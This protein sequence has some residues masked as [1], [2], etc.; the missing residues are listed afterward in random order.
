MIARPL[1]KAS[2]TKSSFTWT[3]E[4][5]EAFESLKKHLSSTPILAFP[6]F[7]EPF[8][9]YTDASV[10]AM[11]AVLAQVQDGK[12]R[13]ICYASKAFSKSQTNYSATKRELLA[14]VTFTRHFKHYLLG[15]KFR[16]VTDHHALQW[17]HNFKDPDGL[18]AR[19]LKKLAAFDYEV[20]HRPGKS[21][22]HADGL[23]RIPIANQV[24]SSQCQEK[25]DEPMKTKF[26]EIVHKN[27][28]LFQSKGS[29]AHCISSEFKMSAG[30][31]RSLKRKFPYNFPEI[32][33][34][35]LFVQK[36]DDRFIY[37]L[38]TKRRFFQK[39]TYD[40]LRQSLEAM[41]Y[42][43]NKHR[44]THIS[45]PKAGCGLDRLEWYKVEH[46]IKEICAQSNITITVYEQSKDEQS[47]KEN[48]TTVR[49]ALG[50]AERHDEAFSKL[51]QWIEKEQLPT[52]HKNYKDFLGSHGNS[53]IN[54]KVYN[55]SMNFC[56][57]NSKLQIAK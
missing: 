4:T 35:P 48:E 36:L 38:V 42:H 21:I 9:L 34:S 17:L 6:D 27:G 32:T 50:Q 15:R 52:L 5:Q 43:A 54:S 14:I 46:L 23:S 25:L 41:T 31:A 47:Q 40:S 12:E 55:S 53:T 28:N 7:K 45:M 11:G 57:E 44:V 10:T 22:G 37:H 49:S 39:P 16:I 20:Q 2:E 3:D 56:A 18:T 33:N 1:H 26:F 24:T 19:R 29:L 13:A 30:I 51:I 8:I